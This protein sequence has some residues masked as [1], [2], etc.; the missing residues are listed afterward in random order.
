M[1][2]IL[3]INIAGRA[4]PIEEDAYYSLKDYIAALQRHF[5]GDDGREIIED[6]ENRIAELFLMR[7]KAGTPAIELSD[8]KKVKETLGEPGDLGSAG[9]QS[10]NTNNSTNT[11]NNRSHSTAHQGSHNH[12]HN[13][14]HQRPH[15]DRLMR[16][17]FDKIIGGVCSG[18]AHYFDV[19]PVIVRLVM[20]LLFFTFGVG[21]VAY[22]IAWAVMP[23][24]T[25]RDQIYPGNP[26]TIHDISENM[27]TELK[28]LKR[29]GEQMSR[30]LN[31]FFSK[32]K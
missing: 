8:V 29:R 9:G 14:G 2:R 25:S 12:K 5:T 3:Q 4:I 16:D 17:P 18:V 7:L 1:Q 13:S 21:L 19:D 10:W 15:Y 22:I 32:K 20:A 11:N 23:A 30:E 28:D 31:D 26:M 6:I 27:A 24:A